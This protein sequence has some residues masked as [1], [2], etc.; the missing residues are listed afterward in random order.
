[1]GNSWRGQNHSATG[2]EKDDEDDSGAALPG[3]EGGSLKS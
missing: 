3:C 2:P 1:M